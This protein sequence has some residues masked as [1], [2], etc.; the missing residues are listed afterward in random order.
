MLIICIKSY[1]Q[2]KH[3]ISVWWNVKFQVVE[4]LEPKGQSYRYDSSTRDFALLS[5]SIKL[6]KPLIRSSHA[7]DTSVFSGFIFVLIIKK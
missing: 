2:N 3:S 1:Y 6:Q 4:I 7:N 5:L